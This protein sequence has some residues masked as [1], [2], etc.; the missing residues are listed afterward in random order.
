M[1]PLVISDWVKSAREG[2]KQ[3]WNDLYRS[4]HPYLLNVALKICGNTPAAKD[5]VQE[6][7]MVAYLKLHHLKEPKAFYTWIER[8]CMNCCYRAIQQGKSYRSLSEI[9]IESQTWWENQLDRKFDALSTQTKL[10]DVLG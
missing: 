9:P 8:I 10:F 1:Q 3:A 6:A 2:N 4:S 5:S 7:F